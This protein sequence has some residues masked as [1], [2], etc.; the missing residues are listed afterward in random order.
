MGKAPGSK[1]ESEG[2]ACWCYLNVAGWIG[3]VAPVPIGML[4]LY[5]IKSGRFRQVVLGVFVFFSSSLN[6][7]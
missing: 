5:V 4:T 3:L 1:H 7:Y 2:G 6:S